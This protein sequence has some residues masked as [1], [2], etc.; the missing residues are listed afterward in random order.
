ME[1]VQSGFAAANLNFR[2]ENLLARKGLGHAIRLLL[3]TV[4]MLAV[5]TT[6]RAA[7]IEFDRETLEIPNPVGFAAIT[8]KLTAIYDFQTKNWPDST[9]H[10]L[11]FIQDAEIAIA[12]RNEIPDMNRRLV[13]TTIRNAVGKTVR[14]SEFS[15]LKTLL[16]TQSEQL[17]KQVQKAIADEMEKQSKR[18]S[19]QSGAS[20]KLGMR[21][22]TAYP[23]H[24]DS[25]RSFATSALNI[26]T[27][28][29]ADGKLTDNTVA[30]TTTY[31]HVRGKLLVLQAYGEQDSLSWTRSASRQWADSILAAN[32]QD[33]KS[34]A[35][36]SS[37]SSDQG[38]D[39]AKAAIIGL[40]SA[41]LW[42]AFDV[43]R[44][45]LSDRIKKD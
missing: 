16:K 45:K 34:I 13:V 41:G 6:I 25:E 21:Q 12:L 8:P 26:Y 27:V 20:L 10:F 29:D 22:L 28:T 42:G 1:E 44:K 30:A 11:T 18:M 43:I 15:E 39:W 9:V 31:L 5:S 23:P 24:D 32:P 2:K 37:P 14:N 17:A 35:A 4:V 36:E 38:I 3:A 7:P 19:G 40:L 33:E